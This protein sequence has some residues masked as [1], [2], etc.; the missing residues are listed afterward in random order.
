M[1]LNIGVINFG[2]D[3]DT[4]PLQRAIGDLQ[5]FRQVINR[6]ARDQKKGAEAH[7]SALA[8]QESAIKKAFQQTLN[9]QQQATKFG[10]PT[11]QVDDTTKAFQR[12]TKELTSGRLSY[13]QFTRAVDAF[14]ARLGRSQRELRAFKANMAA[15]QKAV[16]WPS[17][18]P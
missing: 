2:V 18:Y 6:V 11:K 10:A 4:K 3:A 13:T 12:L 1:A 17:I 15:A 5:K 9:F 7:A 14:N 16:F 8:R